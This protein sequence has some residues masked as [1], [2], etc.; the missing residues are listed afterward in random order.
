MT[1]VCLC[2]F[3]SIF[4]VAGARLDRLTHKSRPSSLDVSTPHMKLMASRIVE[5]GTA[6]TLETVAA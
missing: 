1:I 3:L 2:G 5:G 6:K 4:N